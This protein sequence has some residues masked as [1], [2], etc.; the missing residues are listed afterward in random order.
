MNSVD[1]MEW[2]R[3]ALQ[4]PGEL[5]LQVLVATLI[6][7]VSH[8]LGGK[9]GVDDLLPWWD[10]LYVDRQESLK[11]KQLRERQE[12]IQKALAFNMAWRPVAGNDG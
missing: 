9:I 5:H 10:E 7:V 11:R 12:K 8:A 4:G 3:F 6:S 1:Y 2:Q